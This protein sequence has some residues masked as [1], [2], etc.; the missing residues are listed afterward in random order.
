MSRNQRTAVAILAALGMGVLILDAKS[1]LAGAR[2]GVQLCIQTVIPALFPFFVVSILLTGAL[3]GQRIPFLRPVGKF[4]GLP[5]GGEALLLVGLLG[6]YPVGAQ[7]VAQAYRSGRL[8]RADARRMLGF[9][10][11]AGPAFLFGMLLPMFD[12]KE[13]VWV[14]WLLHLL[15]AL[16]T[17]ALLPG[18]SQTSVILHGEKQISLPQA[19]E[20]AVG[21]MGIVSGWVVFFR[22]LIAVFQRWFLWLLPAA[23]Q[24]ALIGLL[25]LSNGC[26]EL[27]A[28]PSQGI[29]F[30][31]CSGFLS[32]GGL[33]VTM[34]TASVTQ[35]L[36]LGMYLPGKAIQT[37]FSLLLSCICQMLLFPAEQQLYLS[38]SAVMLLAVCV[39]LILVMLKK[40]SRNF[41]KA[42][43]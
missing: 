31:L 24:T 11:N 26:L 14:L 2:E 39:L 34:Q 1:A 8:S 30:I 7:V 3:V 36:G 22:M 19:L 37:V 12:N 41:L 6:G 29:R 27:N 25:E 35:G 23:G 32:I 15:S 40:S 33:C 10:S 43:V 42:A 16:L 21:V 13:A 18:K 4:C 17:G 28:L 9:C 20:R 5:T 38:W